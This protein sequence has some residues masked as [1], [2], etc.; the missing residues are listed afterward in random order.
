MAAFRRLERK[1]SGCV[2]GVANFGVVGEGS[3][4]VWEHVK[5][6]SLGDLNI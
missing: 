5:G 2:S 1:S 3:E 4:I 6:E